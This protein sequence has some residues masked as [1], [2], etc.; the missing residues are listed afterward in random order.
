M[1]WVETTG[2][3]IEEA[4][5]A[6]LDQLAVDESDAE[7]VVLSEPKT[8]LFGRLRG[9]ARVRARVRPASVRPKRARGNGRR[10]EEGPR[11]SGGNSGSRSSSA[12]GAT[13]ATVEAPRT[14]Q[15]SGDVPAGSAG[16]RNRR[17][18]PSSGTKLDAGEG[19]GSAKSNG[20]DV[21]AGD[22]Q[23]P[24][25]VKAP[26]TQRAPRPKSGPSRTKVAK[27]EEVGDVLTL[28]EQ[29]TQAKGFLEGLV[30]ELGMTAS[31][32]TRSI[33]ETTVE[34]AL[35]GA[36]LGL[37]IG[38]GGAT[39][40]ALQELTRTVVQRRPSAPGERIVVEVAGYRAK[41]AEALGRFTRQIVDE[42][43]V[44]GQERA[45]EPMSSADRKVVHDTVNEIAGVE[46]RSEGEDPRRHIVISV[47]ASSD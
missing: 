42:I 12:P 27:E 33:D 4:K 13:P 10:K 24:A 20:T 30:R 3:T 43:L 28:E 7:F 41:R 46:T 31:L 19:A 18:G 47:S 36:E 17:R 34:V 23:S 5:E 6:A 45:L 39:L 9:E 14:I 21:K 8:G 38:P 1:E 37:L 15:D 40:A 16:R 44:S 35:E 29:G 32:S 22:A 11:R 26:T 25:E 2:K